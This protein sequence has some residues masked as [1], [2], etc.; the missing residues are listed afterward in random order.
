MKFEPYKINQENTSESCIHYGT[1]ELPEGGKFRILMPDGM[2]SD[3]IILDI[4]GLK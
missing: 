4:E 1:A 2:M 3:K